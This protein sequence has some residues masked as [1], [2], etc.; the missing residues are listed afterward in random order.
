MFGKEKNV[1]P[2]YHELLGEAV[3]AFHEFDSG[4]T[5]YSGE[6]L[7]NV[8]GQFEAAVRKGRADKILTPE[9][10]FQMLESMAGQSYQLAV[11]GGDTVYATLFESRRESYAKVVKNLGS[12]AVAKTATQTEAKPMAARKK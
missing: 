9:K 6:V 11:A 10:S 2:S 4:L 1:E 3:S 12:T 7:D 8:Y 5:P